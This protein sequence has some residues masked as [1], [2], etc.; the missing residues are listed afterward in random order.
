MWNDG[1]RYIGAFPKNQKK[2]RVECSHCTKVF[3]GYIG[4]S[5]HFAK[6][7]R[8]IHPR[9]NVVNNIPNPD[10]VHDDINPLSPSPLN[11]N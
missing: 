7:H 3:K 6:A 2:I 11:F 9:D 8:S 5:Q 1:S 10:F 4:Y